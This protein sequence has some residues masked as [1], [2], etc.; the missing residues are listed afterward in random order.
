MAAALSRQLL[1][2]LNN[3]AGKIKEL[4]KI[5]RPKAKVPVGISNQAV[6]LQNMTATEGWALMQ[7]NMQLNIELLEEC[8]L[9]KMQDEVPLTELA[10]DRLRDKRGFLKELLN[11]P[12]KYAAKLEGN[13]Q[14]TENFDPYFTD[15]KDLINSRKK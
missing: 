13:N 12:A 10:V 14:E 5:R 6:A 1:L 3:M 4:V 2:N 11:M 8:I 15:V 7:A 9:E